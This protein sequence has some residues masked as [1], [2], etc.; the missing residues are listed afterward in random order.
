MASTYSLHTKYSAKLKQIIRRP[1]P[2]DSIIPSITPLSSNANPSPAGLVFAVTAN[3][4]P[5]SLFTRNEIVPVIA[6]LCPR[7]P[8]DSIHPFPYPEFALDPVHIVARVLGETLSRLPANPSTR[9]RTRTRSIGR[10]SQP[11]NESNPR[12]MIVYALEG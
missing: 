4:N 9:L 8:D 5:S 6:P 11:Q 12:T 3:P 1:S 2:T 7:H 10:A